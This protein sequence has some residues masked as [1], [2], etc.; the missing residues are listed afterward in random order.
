[1]DVFLHRFMQQDWIILLCNVQ[2][3]PWEAFWHMHVSL[4]NWTLPYLCCSFWI[5]HYQCQD[6]FML[7][8][9][10]SN[11]QHIHP[12]TPGQQFPKFKIP[13]TSLYKNHNIQ[14]VTRWWFTFY[15]FLSHMSLHF[16]QVLTWFTHWAKLNPLDGNS[17]TT[18]L[19]KGQKF[20]LPCVWNL[21][22]TFYLKH[23]QHYFSEL[24]LNNNTLTQKPATIHF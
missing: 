24:S 21:L 1:M 8:R 20:I 23:D 9:N 4:D 16:H 19:L 10:A 3:S 7:E 15:E 14:T 17:Q 11:S 12:K 6:L 13:W 18:S 2:Y 22:Q 5:F